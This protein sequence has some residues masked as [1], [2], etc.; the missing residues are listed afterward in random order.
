[1][2]DV[3]EQLVR[4]VFDVAPNAPGSAPAGRSTPRAGFVARCAPTFCLPEVTI[5]GWLS[6]ATE[7]RRIYDRKG[8]GEGVVKSA[9]IKVAVRRGRKCSQFRRRGTE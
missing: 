5:L 9:G 2:P 8:T 3:R 1:M 7:E 6:A 4:V